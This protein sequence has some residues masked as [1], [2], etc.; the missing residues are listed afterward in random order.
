MFIFSFF[1]S[2]FF[3][4]S[5]FLRGQDPATSGTFFSWFDDLIVYAEAEGTAALVERWACLFL[6]WFCVT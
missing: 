1:L 2:L 3:L 6:V 5:F 4:F